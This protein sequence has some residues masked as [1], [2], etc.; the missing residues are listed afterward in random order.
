MDHNQSIRENKQLMNEIMQE[1]Q[2]KVQQIQENLSLEKL[3]VSHA[4]NVK[5]RVISNSE[6]AAIKAVNQHKLSGAGAGA[7]SGVGTGAG[8]MPRKKYRLASRFEYGASPKTVQQLQEWLMDDE[9]D[10]V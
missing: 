9:V 10:Y 6:A 5:G 8:E 1:M 2:I 7:G 3:E 4:F